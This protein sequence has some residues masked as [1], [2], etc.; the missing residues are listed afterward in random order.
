MQKFLWKDLNLKELFNSFDQKQSISFLSSNSN[1]FLK[2]QIIIS[3][4]DLFSYQGIF[5]SDNFIFLDEEGIDLD[6]SFQK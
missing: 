3:R 5:Y 4:E 2:I 1:C 6:K